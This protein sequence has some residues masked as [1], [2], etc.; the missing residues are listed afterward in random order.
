MLLE[1]PDNEPDNLL[2]TSIRS[3]NNIK[4]KSITKSATTATATTNKKRLVFKAP[5]Q[6]QLLGL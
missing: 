2:N 1:E 3:K 6:Y 5:S 4:R